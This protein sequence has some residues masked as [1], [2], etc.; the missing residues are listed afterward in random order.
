MP[1]EPQRAEAAPNSLV[2]SWVLLGAKSNSFG[3]EREEF[4]RDTW[5]WQPLEQMLTAGVRFQRA[6]P[7]L[8]A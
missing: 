8:L 4:D 1:H 5:E 2:I 7:A 6:A 3:L